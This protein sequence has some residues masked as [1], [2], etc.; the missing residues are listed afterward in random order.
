MKG[1]DIQK[2]VDR[3][4]DECFEAH[5]GAFWWN[6]EQQIAIAFGNDGYSTDGRAILEVEAVRRLL[7]AMDGKE[8]G[9]ATSEEDGHGWALACELENAQGVELL[10]G[11]MWE[12][13]GDLSKQQAEGKELKLDWDAINDGLESRKFRSADDAASGVQ[14]NIARA[15]LERNGLC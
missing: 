9:F 5:R 15:V 10:E 7:S 6:E 12:V 1:I 8:I 4:S 13:W 11:M 3:L 14:V 2:I